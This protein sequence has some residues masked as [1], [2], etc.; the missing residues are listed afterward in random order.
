[1]AAEAD[2]EEEE[3]LAVAPLGAAEGLAAALLDAAEELAAASLDAAG[4][5]P[6]TATATSS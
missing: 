2:G 4:S 5:I 6:T 3:E 1:M